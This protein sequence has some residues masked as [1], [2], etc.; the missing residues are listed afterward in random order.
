MPGNEKLKMQNARFAGGKQSRQLINGYFILTQL[1]GT[2]S[3]LHFQF[4]IKSKT[5]RVTQQSHIQA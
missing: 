3:I 2:V 1:H 4:Y 5:S